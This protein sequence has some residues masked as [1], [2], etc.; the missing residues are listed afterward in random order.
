MSGTEL[1]DDFTHPNPSFVSAHRRCREVEKDLMVQVSRNPSD[2]VLRKQLVNVR[3]MGHLLKVGPT[4]AAKSHISTTINSEATDEALIARGAF[5]DRF[6]IR[7]C[8]LV[9]GPTPQESTDHSRPSFRQTLAEVQKQLQRS[10]S[11][12]QEAKKSALARDN[13]RCLLSG[14]MDLN[15]YLDHDELRA[16]LPEGM[17]AHIFSESTNVGMDDP[18]KIFSSCSV[19][20]SDLLCPKKDYAANAWTIIKHFGFSNILKDLE[21]GNIHRLENILTLQYDLHVHF[22]NLALWLEPTVRFPHFLLSRLTNSQDI[23]N[24]YKVGTTMDYIFELRIVPRFVD[25]TSTRSD[26][27][28]PSKEYL[29]I[30]A[31]CCRVAHM[32][33]AVEYLNCLGDDDPFKSKV[34]SY[35]PV[36]SDFGDV[37]AARLYEVSEI[38]SAASVG[39]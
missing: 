22:D 28:L 38:R 23:E 7:T 2:M 27:P 31:A 11:D 25:F 37:L 10:P 16:Q 32:S 13:Y 4:D 17:C 6:F 3:I 34:R 24:R 14:T 35:D 19:V 20:S 12:H 36:G 9:K 21:G 33:G 5:Y 30:H 1:G 18:M 39:A 26:L 29:C 15:S 8:W